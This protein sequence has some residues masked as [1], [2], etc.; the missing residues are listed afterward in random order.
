MFIY[1]LKILPVKFPDLHKEFESGKFV[2][3]TKGNDFSKIA[4]DQAQ[5]HCNKKIKSTAGYIDLVNYDDKEFLRKLE[6]CLPEMH[7][8]LTNFECSS[9]F[10]NQ[11]HKESS[12]SFNI[13]FIEDCKKVYSKILTNPFSCSDFRRLNSSYLFPDVIALPVV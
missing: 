6:L 13:K 5:E 4:L 8:Y 11:R 7:Q 12:K 3:N 9:S 1:D 2:V 10:I